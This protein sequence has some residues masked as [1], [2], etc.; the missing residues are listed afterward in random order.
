MH[1]R[2]QQGGARDLSSHNSFAFHPKHLYDYVAL[3]CPCGLVV[4]QAS[5]H[6]QLKL[7]FAQHRCAFDVAVRHCQIG[8]RDFLEC[9]EVSDGIATTLI[10][11]IVI[12]DHESALSKQH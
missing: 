4:R 3:T 9:H 12:D 11:I 1:V 2:P 5:H 10:R 8:F 6:L 7:S